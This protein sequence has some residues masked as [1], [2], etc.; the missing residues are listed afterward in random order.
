MKKL[1]SHI[2]LL[3]LL[4][5]VVSQIAVYT[6]PFS[7][8]NTRLNT[9]YKAYQ[10]EESEYNTLFIGASTT[11]RH[12]DPKEFDD[13]V[14]SINPSLNIRSFNFG[15]PAN[16]TPQSIYTLDNLLKDKKDHIKYVVLD[17][18]ELTKMGVD[19]LHKKEMLYWYTWSNIGMIMKA[20]WESENKIVNKVGVPVLHAFSFGEKSLMVGMGAAFLEQH[21]GYNLETLALGPDKN[22]FYSLD[23]ELQDYPEGDLSIRYDVLRTEDTINFRTQLCQMLYDKYGDATQN[24]NKTMAKELNKVI[25]DCES[26][27]IQIIFMLSQRLGDRYEYLLPLYNQLPERNK[28]SFANPSEYPQFNDRNN[29]FDLTHLNAP[30]AEIFTKL[31]ADKFLQKI[32]VQENSSPN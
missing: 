18:S 4:Y 26:K 10:E 20:S 27:N 12:V 17:L 29:L 19:N 3:I 31:L 14:N 6:L 5:F 30:G 1:F 11:Y 8:G 2:A 28:I 13:Y 21:L 7:W 16:R 22:G 15:I 25:K 32:G 23:Q 24:P 9:K